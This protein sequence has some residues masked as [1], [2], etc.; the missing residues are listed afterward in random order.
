VLRENPLADLLSTPPP[1]PHRDPAYRRGRRAARPPTGPPRTFVLM[2]RYLPHM[3]WISRAGLLFLS[4]FIIDYFLPLQQRD[5]RISQIYVI[6]R[7]SN[8]ALYDIVTDEGK[9]L[10]LDDDRAP[11][12]F[13]DGRIRLLLTPVLGSIIYAGTPDGRYTEFIARMYTS[14]VFF[15]IL[16]LLTSGLAFVYRAEVEFCFNLNL[17]GLALLIINLLL[18]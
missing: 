2:K 12:Y 14:Q 18:I 3:M 9:R 11:S 10:R 8:D 1:R 4:I 16:L 17:V 7:K 5:D 13:P 6:V 15:P